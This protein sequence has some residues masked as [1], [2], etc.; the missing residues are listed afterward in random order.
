MHVMDTVGVKDLIRRHWARRAVDF[1]TGPTH[2]LLS[3]DQRQAWSALLVR[4]AG[5][6]PLDVLDVGS[7]TGFL[8]LQ[9]AMLGHRVTGLDAAEEMLSRARWKADEGELPVRFQR[10]DAEHLPFVDAAFDLLVERHV[11]WTLPFPA[12]ALRD[13][14]RVL[15]PGR[16]V[17]VIEG[18]W[19]RDGRKRTDEYRGI[20]H[21]LPLYGGRRSSEL[22]NILAEA[23]FTS[24]DVEPLMDAALWGTRPEVERYA[25][26]GCKPV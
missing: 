2:G 13:W 24:L 25:L 4:W 22:L 1:D 10:G 12:V 15:R 19:R 5:S 7:G 11:I 8:A 9:F 20:E 14:L 26:H 21:Y 17:I 16:R 23:G 18:D 3:D 6:E